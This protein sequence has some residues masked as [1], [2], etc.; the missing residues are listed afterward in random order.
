MNIPT[1]LKFEDNFEDLA[2]NAL[3][4]VELS[5]VK[6]R[7]TEEITDQKIQV[8]FETEGNMDDAVSIVQDFRKYNAYEG[9]LGFV[10]ATNRAKLRNHSDKLAKVR[11]LMMPENEYLKSEFYQILETKEISATTDGMGIKLD[12]STV[13]NVKFLLLE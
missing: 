9:T 8:I 1:S 13:F 3:S 10:I 4:K 7:F 6:A 5:G 2:V 11:Y 12:K